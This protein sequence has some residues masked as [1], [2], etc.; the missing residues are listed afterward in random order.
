M[1]ETLKVAVEKAR[2][3]RA[4]SE[5]VGFRSHSGFHEANP[6]APWHQD[7]LKSPNQ[8]AHQRTMAWQALEKM[9]LDPLTLRRNR[10]VAHA[11]KDPAHA[12]FDVL[13]TQV[14]RAFDQHG[15]SQLGITSPTGSCGTTFVA[16]NLALSL[17]RQPECNTLLIDFDLKSP[18]LSSVLGI[19]GAPPVSE[20]LSGDLAPGHALLRVG[21]NLALGLNSEP[22]DDSSETLQSKATRS[23]LQA[24]QAQLSPDITI[25]D[26]PP[27][28]HRDDVLGF[29]PQLDAVLLVI[30]GGRTTPSEV[31]ECERLLADQVPILGMLLNQAED[32]R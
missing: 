10:I 15:W 23:A 3:E 31:A 14:V 30:G 5:P 9:E 1:I 8:I 25:Y 26:L 27:L 17:A 2:V 28:L 13:R 20:Y 11:R 21:D 16:A 18:A 24:V 7:I 22:L 6:S 29:A 19:R 4:G 32:K 12:A